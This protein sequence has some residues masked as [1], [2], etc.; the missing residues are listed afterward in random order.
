MEF[1]RSR[2]PDLIG[3]GL[4]HLSDE[5][6]RRSNSPRLAFVIDELFRGLATL[7]SKLKTVVELSSSLQS[8]PPL[9]VSSLRS[10][11]KSPGQFSSYTA[12][13]LAVVVSRALTFDFDPSLANMNRSC[14]VTHGLRRARA[15]SICARGI[16]VAD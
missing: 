16:W 13:T 14:S 8:T 3:L 7:S 6:V 10:N 12:T 5:K 2:T 4:T 9:R 1:G 15:S 11:L